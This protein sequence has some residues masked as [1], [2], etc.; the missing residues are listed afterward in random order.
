MSITVALAGY[1]LSPNY[2]DELM[3]ALTAHLL[4]RNTRIRIVSPSH[5]FMRNM[6]ST[7]NMSPGLETVDESLSEDI[8][9]LLFIGGGYF[10]LTKITEPLWQLRS[11]HQRYVR[12][13][14]AAVGR[15]IP[16]HIVGPEV[17]PLLWP[18]LSRTWRPI[19]DR[20]RSNSVRN[21]PSARHTK[22]YFGKRACVIGDIVLGITESWFNS[23]DYKPILDLSKSGRWAG[24]H[25][26]QKIIASNYLSKTFKEELCKSLIKSEFTQIVLFYDQPID[27]DLS[28]ALEIKDVLSRAGKTVQIVRY[29]NIFELT[30]LLRHID[31]IFTTK[32]HV[33]V[34]SLSFGNYAVSFGTHPK[35]RRFYDEVGLSTLYSSFL[36]P[37][38]SLAREMDR[39][40]AAAKE[41]NHDYLRPAIRAISESYDNLFSHILERR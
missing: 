6:D 2:G 40:L 23:I 30:N 41:W 1:N 33:G 16:Y 31:V 27:L 15:G 37:R 19:F 5:S 26:T 38:R 36:R 9:L 10:G 11:E 24:V 34:V 21:A 3:F 18:I 35:I 20:A 28:A 8:D 39:H 22:Q 12:I 17:G 4:P 29:S 14:A 25:L 32:L 13:A 7:I